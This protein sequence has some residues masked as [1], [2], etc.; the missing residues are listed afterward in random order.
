RARIAGND[1]LPG[2]RAKITAQ[3]PLAE[4]NGFQATL[5]SLTGGEGLYTLEFDHYE[6]APPQ[7]Q[8]ALE[9]E[10]RP[11]AEERPRRLPAYCAST[12]PVSACTVS[13]N[14]PTRMTRSRTTSARPSESNATVRCGEVSIPAGLRP[15]KT[16]TS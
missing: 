2:R 8:K 9:A 1:A 6:M 10:F 4:L 5:K 7:I 3:V 16:G 13:A 11:R 15:P 14:E 12:A